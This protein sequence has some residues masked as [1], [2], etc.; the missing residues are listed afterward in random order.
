[1]TCSTITHPKP[2]SRAA[3]NSSCLQVGSGAL[4]RQPGVRI[5]FDHNTCTTTW[6]DPR[7]GPPPPQQPQPQSAFS[8]GVPSGRS[9]SRLSRSQ[10]NPQRNKLLRCALE[11]IQA[12]VS[13]DRR[14]EHRTSRPTLARA[15]EKQY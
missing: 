3:L 4:T 6:R 13:R 12:V 11:R 10:D 1:I 2:P 8:R 15:E 14:L 5:L 9:Q 7:L